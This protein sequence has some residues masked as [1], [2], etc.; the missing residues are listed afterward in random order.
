MVRDSCHQK[1][2][3]G[4]ALPRHSLFFRARRGIELRLRQG[5][6]HPSRSSGGFG[7]NEVF[8]DCKAI[9]ILTCAYSAHSASLKSRLKLLEPADRE[10]GFDHTTPT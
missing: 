8:K 5:M 6:V 7:S 4:L 2:T 10:T 1:R 9:Q 3:R